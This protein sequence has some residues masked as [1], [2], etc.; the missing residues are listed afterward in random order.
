MLQKWPEGRGCPL[1]HEAQPCTFR[2]IS[3][4]TAIIPKKTS[5]GYIACCKPVRQA[6]RCCSWVEC[7]GQSRANAPHAQ[8][9]GRVPERAKA[10]A[11][12]WVTA[13]RCQPGSVGGEWLND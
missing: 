11:V 4:K 2:E 12:V 6:P 13:V 10:G 1:K 7:A 8:V 5:N 3:E 9:V